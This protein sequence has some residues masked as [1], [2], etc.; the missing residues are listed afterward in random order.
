MPCSTRHCKQ[1][2][3]L[4]NTLPTSILLNTTVSSATTKHRVGGTLSAL[5]QH[6]LRPGTRPAPEI[7]LRP[8][9]VAGS[10][11]GR[12]RDK[13][14][15]VLKSPLPPAT[16]TRTGAA[17]GSAGGHKREACFA[18]R[19]HIITQIADGRA[20]HLHKNNNSTRG[21]ATA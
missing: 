19:G 13:T 6:L 15:C 5:R 11:S 3:V 1:L 21:Q 4:L 2:V 9:S 20:T 16:A 10:T 12:C 8:L 18:T 17:G 7:T 14:H